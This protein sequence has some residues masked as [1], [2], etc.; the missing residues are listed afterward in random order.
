VNCQHYILKA[1]PETQKTGASPLGIGA[2]IPVG[3]YLLINNIGCNLELSLPARGVLEPLFFFVDTSYPDEPDKSVY[4][5]DMHALI[6]NPNWHQIMALNHYGLIRLIDTKNISD[7]LTKKEQSGAQQCFKS[8]RDM[9]WQGDIAHTM[10]IDDRLWSS[11][12]LGYKCSDPAQPGLL[13]SERLLTNNG[14]LSPAKKIEYSVVVPEVGLISAMAV[15]LQARKLAFAA[16]DKVYL[17]TIGHPEEPFSAKH[18]LWRSS[19]NFETQFLAFHPSGILMAAG[20][21]LGLQEDY[22]DPTSLVGGAFTALDQRDG[23]AHYTQ[24][25]KTK[26]AWGGGGQCLT[27]SRDGRYLL[28]LDRYAGLYSWDIANGRQETV[29]QGNDQENSASLGLVHLAWI[30]DRLYCG[31][32]RAQSDLHVYDFKAN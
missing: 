15:D 19:V 27:L 13:I 9:L 28:G 22:L 8:Q 3:P 11:S 10:L 5:L 23:N 12:P 25:F 32:N 16:S 14:G 6:Y 30:E 21:D 31:F 1:N 18:V 20:Y 7:R 26:L 4:D 2:L 17:G 24:P 29:C